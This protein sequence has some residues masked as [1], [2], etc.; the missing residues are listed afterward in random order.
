MAL[1]KVRLPALA[2]IVFAVPVPDVV[3]APDTVPKPLSDPL[4]V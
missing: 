4:E 3:S 1:L 2:V